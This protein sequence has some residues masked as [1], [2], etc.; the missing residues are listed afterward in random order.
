MPR[1]ARLDTPVTLHHVMLQ[2]IERGNIV[3]DNKDREDFLARMGDYVRATT[4]CVHAWMLMDKSCPYPASQRHR[5]ARRCSCAGFRPDRPWPS[6]AVLDSSGKSDLTALGYG[7]KIT[8]SCQ[9]P[10][11]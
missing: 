4:T 1:G 7:S 8:V 10:Q 3:N 2:G 5:G 9:N 11:N 6:I